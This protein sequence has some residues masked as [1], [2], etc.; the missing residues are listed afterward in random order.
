LRIEYKCGHIGGCTF[1]NGL[2]IAEKRDFIKWKYSVGF[3]GTKEKCYEC[4]RDETVFNQ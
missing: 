4:Y 1:Y 3:K 2:T